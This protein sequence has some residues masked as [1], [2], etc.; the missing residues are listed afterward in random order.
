MAQMKQILW[1]YV[2]VWSTWNAMK[3]ASCGPRPW[4]L[5]CP[6]YC[7][8]APICIW[9]RAVVRP[10]PRAH[11]AGHSVEVAI[12]CVFITTVFFASFGFLDF[13]LSIV[14]TVENLK[15]KGKENSGC[16]ICKCSMHN[17]RNGKIKL[18]GQN[19]V[20]K[21]AKRCIHMCSNFKPVAVT[22][23]C[24]GWEVPL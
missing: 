8:R 17:G 9:R 12:A 24:L 7:P 5:Y 20:T 6:P 1:N 4:R 16:E 21:N 11:F 14:S 22:H 10:T 19:F 2:F 15:K 3:R 13:P 18:K 23:P